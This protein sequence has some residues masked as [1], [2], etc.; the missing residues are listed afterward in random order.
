MP[1]VSPG[2]DFELSAE[3]VF[4]WRL[5][6]LACLLFSPVFH[7]AAYAADDARVCTTVFFSPDQ[8]FDNDTGSIYTTAFGYADSGMFFRVALS[9]GGI[10]GEN[11]DAQG[12][13]RV[14]FYNSIGTLVRRRVSAEMDGNATPPIN[15]PQYRW[16]GQG[17]SHVNYTL[18]YGAYTMR[19]YTSMRDPSIVKNIT[20]G[21]TS[22]TI[23]RPGDMHV[24]SGGILTWVNTG[25]RLTFCQA[26][27]GDP[28]T[29]DPTGL[30]TVT[31]DSPAVGQLTN[32][33]RNFGITAN[34]SNEVFVSADTITGTKIAKYSTATETW[35]AYN[36]A[37]QAM[38]SL[39]EDEWSGLGIDNNDSVYVGLVTAVN[40]GGVG[41]NAEGVVKFT[42]SGL[43]ATVA[44]ISG[45]DGRDIMDVAPHPSGRGAVYALDRQDNQVDQYTT[46]LTLQTN[47][48]V[49]F[50]GGSPEGSIWVTSDSAIYATDNTVTPSRFRKINPDGSI[51]YVITDGRI[52]NSAGICVWEKATTAETFVIVAGRT[53]NAITIYKETAN[54]DTPDFVRQI[55][56]DVY[57]LLSPEGIAVDADS[58]IFVLSRG[59]S[60]IKKFNTEGVFQEM[61]GAPNGRF[62]QGV[63]VT[64][65]LTD[66]YALDDAM[67]LAV[68]SSGFI[69]ALDQ[70]DATNPTVFSL[71]K[72]NSDGSPVG[73][74]ADLDALFNPGVINDEYLEAVYA[75]NSIYIVGRDNDARVLRFSAAG[76]ILQHLGA[77]S[78]LDGTPAA[79]NTGADIVGIASGPF[80]DRA[81]NRFFP[82][83]I[84]LYNTNEEVEVW[85]TDFSGGAAITSFTPPKATNTAD[86]TNPHFFLVDYAGEIYLMDGTASSGNYYLSRWNAAMPESQAGTNQLLEVPY[87]QGSGN[88]QLNIPSQAVWTDNSGIYVKN[89]S[90]GLY[91]R[92]LWLN[93][94]A[95][96]R[97]QQ[98]LFSWEGVSEF[99]ITISRVEDTPFVVSMSIDDLDSV[100][101]AGGLYYVGLCTPTFRI[102]FNHNMK[103]NP[104]SVT[105]KIDPPGALGFTS[106]AKTSYGG[107]QWVGTI[108]ISAAMN[109]GDGV[110][111]AVVQVANAYDTGPGNTRQ[112]PDPDQS[113]LDLTDDFK[114]FTIDLVGPQVSVSSPPSSGDST[115]LATYPITGVVN[116]DATGLD[117]TIEVT[118]YTA[119]SGGIA[120]STSSTTGLAADGTFSTSIDLRGPAPTSNYIEIVAIDKVKNRT[121]LARIPVSRVKNVGNAYITPSS[122][123]VVGHPRSYRIIYTAA[124]ALSQ[125][126]LRITVPAAWSQPQKGAATTNGYVTVVETTAVRDSIFTGQAVVC[127][128]V[129]MGVGQ[130]LTIVYGDS[131]LSSL[132]MAA[133][134]FDAP[135]DDP[136]NT[137][138]VE[139]MLA[140]ETQ[141]TSVSPAGGQ[142]LIVP[143]RDSS[144]AVAL[145]ETGPSPTPGGPASDDTVT[146]PKGGETRVMTVRFYN[147]NFGAHTHRVSQVTLTVE[148]D[149]GGVALWQNVASKVTLKNTTEGIT[150]TDVTSM[151]AS[152]SLTIAPSN[153]T[154][155]QGLS[156]DMEIWVTAS[157]SATVDTVRFYFSAVSAITAV[158]STSGKAITVLSRETGVAGLRTGEYD[159]IGLAPADT[160]FVSCDTSIAPADVS[161]RQTNVRVMDLGFTNSPPHADT[162]VNS[163]RVD[164]IVFSTRFD[165]NAVGCTPAHVI[166]GI[167]VKDAVTGVTYG[168]VDTPSL[169]YTGDTVVVSLAGLIVASGGTVNTQVYLDIVN[170]TATIAKF[171]LRLDSTSL[172]S[173]KDQVSQIA[174][175]V[176]DDPT[177][178][179]AF[180]YQTDTIAIIRRGRINIAS[181]TLLRTDSTI[182]THASGRTLTAGSQFFVAIRCTASAN[183]G[184]VRVVPADTD[185]TF[186]IGGTSVT[187]E[188]SV[189][190][191]AAK[192]IG[193]GSEDTI[194]YGVHQ[195]G[196]TSGDLTIQFSDTGGAGSTSADTRPRF[197]DGHDFTEPDVVRAEYKLP[198]LTDSIT[199]AATS[200][201]VTAIRIDTQYANP[202]ETAVPIILFTIKNN[203]GMSRRIDSI[204]VQALSA[205]SAIQ[206]VRLY[207]D[208]KTTDTGILKRSDSA[209][210]ITGFDTLV[211]TGTLQTSDSSVTLILSPAVTIASSRTE[212]FFVAFDFENRQT[213]ND[214]FDARVPVSGIRAQNDT[215]FPLAVVNSTGEGRVEVVAERLTISPDTQ[216]VAIGSSVT[217]G[218]SVLDKY[219]NLDQF[220]NYDSTV[221]GYNLQLDFAIRDTSPEVDTTYAIT[222][223]SGMTSVN[224]SA[225]MGVTIINGR[226]TN[227]VGQVT[228]TDTAVGVLSATCT[229]V[230]VDSSAAVQFLRG[231]S[232]SAVGV[233]GFDSAAADSRAVGVLFFR[234]SNF[235]TVNA[236][237]TTIGI[238]SLNT[239]DTDV[240]AVIVFKDTN[241]NGFLD[242]GVDQTIATGS[243]TNG[244]VTFS[245]LNILV[246]DGGD[247]L[248]MVGYNINTTVTDWNRIDARC[249]TLLTGGQNLAATPLNSSPDSAIDVRA[250]FLE[251]TPQTQSAGIGSNI[252]VV[253]SAKDSPQ[254]NIDKDYTGGATKVQFTLSGSGTWD[255]AGTNLGAEVYPDG[256][257][258]RIRGN[259]TLGQA[260]LVFTDA[261]AEAITLG[262]TVSP[263]LPVAPSVNETGTYT[264]QTGI[265]VSANALSSNNRFPNDTNVV[266]LSFTVTA[267]S[268]SESVLQVMVEWRGTSTAD[269]TNLRLYRDVDG[270]GV[271]NVAGGDTPMGDV[272][273]FSAETV[274][275]R[276]RYGGDTVYVADG[277]SRNFFFVVDVV[278]SPTNGDTLDARLQDSSITTTWASLTHVPNATRNSTGNDTIVVPS[279][280]LASLAIPSN[281]ATPGATDL[282]VGRYTLTNGSAV[283]DT[284]TRIIITNSGKVDSRDIL[285]VGVFLDRDTDAVFDTG[286]DYAFGQETSFS[287]GTRETAVFYSDSA[288]FAGEARTMFVVY[289][290]KSTMLAT[291]GDTIDC[292]V[293]VDSITTSIF[294]G[295]IP[296][297]ALSSPD[298][299]Y[300]TVN[301]G[302]I[303]GDSLAITTA[304]YA[305]GAT[306]VMIGSFSVRNTRTPVDSVTSVTVWNDTGGHPDTG[307]LNVRIYVDGNKNNVY[308]ANQDTLF[309]AADSFFQRRLVRT[310]NARIGTANDTV[311]LLVLCDLSTT[312]TVDSQILRAIIETGGILTFQSDTAA[313]VRLRSN[314]E[315]RAGINV[316]VA[317]VGGRDSHLIAAG[318]TTVDET[319]AVT[320]TVRDTYGNLGQGKLVKLV[321][322]DSGASVTTTNPMLSDTTGL[323]RFFVTSASAGTYRCSAVI[324][325]NFRIS[326]MAFANFLSSRSA[327]DT[328]F[329][330]NTQRSTNTGAARKYSAPLSFSRTTAGRASELRYN[331]TDYRVYHDHLGAGPTLLWEWTNPATIDSTH[332]APAWT[333]MA[334]VR[335]LKGAGADNVVF[336][337]FSGAANFGM[338]LYYKAW[339][340]AAG[341][342]PTRISPN[343]TRSGAANLMFDTDAL[344][345]QFDV[346]PSGD[347]V[348][349]AFD[350]QLITWTAVGATFN[351]QV[352]S[353]TL[354]YL[355]LLKN[356]NDSATIAGG[357]GYGGAYIQYPSVSPDGLRVAFTVVYRDPDWDGAP[358]G[359]DSAEIYVLYDLAG[360]E[361]VPFPFQR[362]S[363]VFELP[364][365]KNGHLVRITTTD[366]HRFAWQPQWSRDGSVLFFSAN[367]TNS[368]DYDVFT[369]TEDPQNA[370]NAAG[371]DFN[372]YMIYYDKANETVPYASIPVLKEAGISEI[373]GEMSSDGDSIAYMRTTIAQ[374]YEER[375]LHV[376]SHATVTSAGGILY[377]SGNVI[378]VIGADASYGN[379]FMIAVRRPD[380]S[381]AGSESVI[382]SGLAKKFFNPDTPTA[383]VYFA[384]SIRIFLY[385]AA[386][387]FNDTDR[388]GYDSDGDGIPDRTEA[389]IAAYY[390]T[391]S[392]WTEYPTVRYP[393]ENK[394]EFFTDHFSLYGAG[395]PMAVRALAFGGSVADVVAYPNPWRADGATG[396][397]SPSDERYGI[398]LTRMPGQDVRVRIFTLA[399][400]VVADAT[401][402]CNNAT[403]TNPNL[404]VTA[405]IINDGNALGTVS[406]NL[407]N[408]SGRAV[409]SGVYLIMLEGPGG[410]AVRK[411]AVIR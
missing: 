146:L 38:T 348:V 234:I 47:S 269:V 283:V 36:W 260:N 330:N 262:V 98:F 130:S 110:G 132:G 275:F 111:D 359:S 268:A 172:I 20:G 97:L 353:P 131:T 293:A 301:L 231:L 256:T 279:F 399:G 247:S 56:D 2:S 180:K 173:A 303:F 5:M 145:I 124:Q 222:M 35:L 115:S 17:D 76:N 274:T 78:R 79:G 179:D 142:S 294:A 120:F 229:S 9:G 148:S 310:G 261:T 23:D 232:A 311:G 90:T 244:F 95:N 28:N 386:A 407:A 48:L 218:L 1:F 297:A 208:G 299:I 306:N 315:A 216:I 313:A 253:V 96:N 374:H 289:Q 338:N 81:N 29:V 83:A 230:I 405:A 202:A 367:G 400:E 225:G 242:S 34:S 402:N 345:D 128:G 44:A 235:S 281:T 91:E 259:L 171:R 323:V 236:T 368:F 45:D 380:S 257:A 105:V 55:Q 305:P 6:A 51:R 176:K 280:T 65:N 15:Q 284:I 165:T 127:S 343:D 221:Q 70:N 251:F 308:E 363:E 168:S 103:T 8:I 50:G 406:W 403:S 271:F 188:F 388:Q 12:G 351:P 243:F 3:R 398:K 385:Y 329:T 335:S 182:I 378:A 175:K 394:I 49:D 64:A 122:E 177:D 203:Q 82:E 410:R 342:L 252:T 198:I 112:D 80:F 356:P 41:N 396:A 94:R 223:T 286:L 53:N 358:T 258:Q 325:T 143:L 404:R 137:F 204:V 304:T 296:G 341:T 391:G 282:V 85:R 309:A 371:V 263:N 161:T 125:D 238:R 239:A 160:L 136:S 74:I 4:S 245:G 59:S 285:R 102:N 164:Q 344:F 147:S 276:P 195:L 392:A 22:I 159:I 107:N 140:G 228:I 321:F 155:A 266:V 116:Y 24:S 69:Y 46:T 278:S 317:A 88:S 26:S 287:F 365:T 184:S 31:L 169:P 19:V 87:G 318:S 174:V 199:L 240:S 408:N 270:N 60:S 123:T 376:S 314:G 62:I 369:Q 333:S 249:D 366:S 291:N 134:S 68:D 194:T 156:R 183:M 212:T 166:R 7:S 377:D 312:L 139:L 328:A 189:T 265:S 162:P 354:T 334:R 150:F 163:I 389:A 21:F 118:N 227:G 106:L 360:Y 207:H 58:A 237:C 157:P 217:L 298:S 39:T 255:A 52:N 397:L 135:L 390:W 27:L 151:P 170:E 63:D 277:T 61:A 192:T 339:G 215:F 186:M 273:S 364:R 324:D 92:K 361:H 401:V 108:G 193:A 254:G 292:L 387:H 153:L 42:D 37:T 144:M 89:P 290:L 200:F 154:I 66:S 379:G 357:Y 178:P 209:A 10:V 393:A 75:A 214:T 101:Y 71:K 375:T 126:T 109:D 322:L 93:D 40:G 57:N 210:A 84:Y 352:D 350:G 226:L 149:T 372:T 331:G 187:S 373:A 337:G 114:N 13:Y 326:S 241:G 121:T 18:P 411:V 201:N 300:L 117:A 185:L 191:P 167:R 16:N 14:E 100:Y 152:Q 43:I 382:I 77:T 355:T 264:F 206:R 381:P 67:A 196:F 384:D 86:G 370:L 73:V 138:K 316:L 362:H 25:N 346:F 129:T 272:G 395:L 246:V 219:G 119:A 141:Y 347:R 307:I 190:A 250:E 33:D 409:A 340:A 383:P 349:A 224:P 295:N 327:N 158:D 267:A 248:F 104:E 72:W 336:G 30:R 302:D 319:V 211:A 213:D 320:V 11:E 32:S 205:D 113:D 133:S 288:F 233:N 181:W 54:G 220:I 99:P 197:F 332:P